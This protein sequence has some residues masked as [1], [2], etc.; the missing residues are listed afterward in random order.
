M[1]QRAREIGIR[2]ALGATRGRIF[3]ELFTEGAVLIVA[4]VGA[5]MLTSVFLRQLVASLVFGVSALDPLTYGLAAVAFL[6]TALAAVLIPARRG[7]NI[8]PLTALRCE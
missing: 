5:G 7:S 6:G 4:G 2:L 1:T 8:Q 3:A